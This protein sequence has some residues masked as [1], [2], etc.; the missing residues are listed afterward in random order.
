MFLN[1]RFS[2]AGDLMP[3]ARKIHDGKSEFDIWNAM[4][5][6]KFKKTYLY[7]LYKHTKIRMRKELIYYIRHIT[8]INQTQHLYKK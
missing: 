2:N 4:E 1:H 3:N 5:K 8:H 6:R 7:H